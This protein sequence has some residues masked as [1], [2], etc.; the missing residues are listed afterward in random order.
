NAAV[1]QNKIAW[2]PSGVYKVS[3]LTLPKNVSVSGGGTQSYVQGRILM[4]SGDYITDLKLGIAGQSIGITNSEPVTGLN[5]ERVHFV[6][7]GGTNDQDMKHVFSIQTEALNNS[8]FTDCTIETNSGAWG[9]G[10]AIADNG[11]ASSTLHDVTFLRL[12]IMPQPRMGFEMIGRSYLGVRTTDYYNIKIIDSII[13]PSGSESISFDGP[14]RDLLVQGSLFKGSGTNSYYPWHQGLEFNGSTKATAINNTFN[15]SDGVW[16]NLHCNN[17]TF[18]N[19]YFDN[20]VN[21]L[22][23]TP[24]SDPTGWGGQCINCIFKDNQMV[25]GIGGSFFSL[26]TA[27]TGNQFVG[28]VFWNKKNPTTVCAIYLYNSSTGNVLQSNK[29][30]YKYQWYS[31]NKLCMDVRDGSTISEISN[32][33]NSPTSVP[34]LNPPPLPGLNY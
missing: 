8:T 4:S 5:V 28:N 23:S 29:F 22:N 30:Y 13:E 31:D 1:T 18:E 7:G 15:R 20:T 16:L 25:M 9:N 14:G 19:N 6:G 26:D 12:H 27:S 3:S 32:E 10:I 34:V 11:V 33:Y 24:T 17:C 21:N 2:V